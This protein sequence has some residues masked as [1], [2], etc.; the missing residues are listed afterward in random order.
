MKLRHFNPHHQKNSLFFKVMVAVGAFMVVSLILAGGI[1]V[2]KAILPSEAEF[3]AP[4]QVQK[5]LEPQKQKRKV[6]TKNVQKRNTSLVKRINIVQPKQINTPQVTISLPSGMGGEG[7]E[8]FSN[9]NMAGMSNLGKIKIDIPEFDLFGI[10]GASDRVLI[11]FDVT[12]KTMTGE[13]GALPACNVVKNEIATLVRGLP[14][15]CLFNVMAFDM[16]RGQKAGPLG[17]G[18]EGGNI[19]CIE[20]FRQNLV[21]ANSANKSSFEA[22][23]KGI[24]ESAYQIGIRDGNYELRFPYVPFNEGFAYQA[25]MK[26]WGWRNHVWERHA[27]VYWYMAYQ[28]AI[29]QGAG[30]IYFLTT[31]WP[32]AEEFWIKM[33]PKQREKYVADTK[34]NAEDFQKKGG[35]LVSPEEKGKYYAIARARASELI[36]QEND[37]RVKKG[38]PEMVIRDPWGYAA[39]KRIPEALEA[40]TKKTWDDFSPELK[41]PKAHTNA[42]LLAFYEPIFKKVYDEKGLKRPVFNM[43]IMLPRA[44]DPEWQKKYFKNA[45]A[46]ARQNNGGAV[47]ILRGAK[48]VS[49]YLAEKPQKSEK[50]GGEGEDKKAPAKK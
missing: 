34:K 17:N 46:W 28:A 41:D 29:E 22:W 1:M 7:T 4:K 12:S 47:R 6:I 24:N 39:A 10:K 50:S 38:I 20:I 35:T 18:T 26:K 40:M 49:E 19:N 13:M 27:V 37:A 32:L 30:V 44:G 45:S 33:T 21:L 36:K 43:I 15:T 31:H 2:T 5:D 16:E 25:R 11:C 9:V 42:S 8:G 3:E 48:P 14:S 23:I